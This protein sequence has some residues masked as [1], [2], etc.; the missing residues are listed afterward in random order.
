MHE[1]SADKDILNAAQTA[2]KSAG[3]KFLWDEQRAIAIQKRIH[4]KVEDY[5]DYDF[6]ILQSYALNTFFDLAQ[7]Y[8]EEQDVFMVCVMI[9]KTFFGLDVKIYVLDSQ[10]RLK[11]R[12]SSGRAS[13]EGYEPH[14][15]TVPSVVGETFYI[16]IKGKKE[17]I[18]QLP[19]APRGD[20]IGLITT[21][22]A[23][24]LSSH[25]K[26]FLEKYANRLGFQLH[27]RIIGRRNRDHLEFIKSLVHDIGHNVIVPNMYFKIFYR[28][29]AAKINALGEIVNTLK[30]K[31][32]NEGGAN[33]DIGDTGLY[34]NL[35]YLHSGMREQYN[36][37]YSHYENQS[38]F[39][40]TLLRRSHFE[41][42]R[43]VLE[44]RV[45]NFKS[46]IIDP[47][48]ER[49]RSR[50]QE[51][52][53]EINI[54]QG[55]VPDQE[56]EVVAD[57]GLISQVY[58]NLFSNAVKYARES[59][60]V[61]AGHNRKFVAYGW[62][63][64]PDYFGPGESGIK[65]NVFTTGPCIPENQRDRIFQEGF[66]AANVGNEQGT[67]HGLSF[68]REVVE[69]HGGRIGYEAT[70]MGNN[71][72]FILPQQQPGKGRCCA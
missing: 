60:D 15:P 10:N 67:G 57:I 51:R 70:P 45:C 29:L 25:D 37:I 36:E 31:R 12:G 16:P 68:I 23:T 50:F 30:E 46:Q 26:L 27:N 5:S 66:R 43:Y 9:P 54:E 28:Q 72:Y 2:P 19:F 14:L 18:S 20:I 40:E 38:L 48:L 53:I 32:D 52:G 33:S 47:Q 4:E 1:H 42:G 21:G 58:A 59:Y 8:T 22:P 65:L 6:T 62:E 44:K 41:Q 35:K 69:L 39:L 11:L 7:E 49:F 63:T 61:A 13:E 64:L 24:G 55:G 17:L 34:S 56:L 71:F 3:Q